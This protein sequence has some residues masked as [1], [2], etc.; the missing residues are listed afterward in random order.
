MT[1]GLYL[2]NQKGWSTLKVLI[3]NN[4]QEHIGYVVSDRDLS[5]E[6]DFFSNIA[7]ECLTAGI[8]LFTRKEKT[9][10][11]VDYKLAIGWRWLIA[12]SENLIVLHDSILP[13]FRG[14]APLVNTLIK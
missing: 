11:P 1:I 3:D 5:V 7:E 6:D 2:M 4:F 9:I 13:K 8:A 10:P 12:E 14:F